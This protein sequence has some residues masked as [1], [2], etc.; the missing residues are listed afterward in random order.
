MDMVCTVFK[1]ANRKPEPVSEEAEKLEVATYELLTGLQKL[2]G[3]NGAEVDYAALWVWCQEVRR[4]A[5]EVDREK[6]TDRRV[7][8]CSH[9]RLP[10]KPT[11]PGLTR[12]FGPSLSISRLKKWSG[13]LPLSDSICGGSTARR[14]V[15]GEIRSG[16]SQNS[17]KTGLARCLPRREP[18]PC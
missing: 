9:M 11:E 17:A 8:A 14:L 5:V 18:R 13:G 15:R 7:G 6:I 12:P 2:P 3:Q 10:A 4:I 16:C 1:P